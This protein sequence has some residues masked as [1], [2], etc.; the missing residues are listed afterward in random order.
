[1]SEKKWT[2][3]RVLNYVSNVV[4]AVIIIIL[5]V[6]SWRTSFQGW[7]QSLTMSNAHFH[8]E[9]NDAIPEYQKNWEL[10]S[11]DGELVNFAEFEGHPI[12]LSFW[13]TWCGP[14]RAEM[15]SLKELSQNYN[16]DV[17]FV[18]ATLESIDVVKGT[19]LD[20]EY[21]FLYSTQSY[22]PFFEV[23]SYPTLVIMDKEMN[24]V[25][26]SVGAKDLNTEENISFLNSL[27]EN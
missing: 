24:M 21:D 7:F 26:H 5:I 20:K 18:A 10:F 23:E 4:L 9:R 27:L 12:V 25:Y 2:T 16:N 1:M 14:C 3:K 6:P 11:M 17:L 8:A 22:P 19:D 13:A 15:P